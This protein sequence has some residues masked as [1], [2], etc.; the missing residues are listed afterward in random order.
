MEWAD[1]FRAL[2]V[3]TN[4]DTPHDAQVARGFGAEGIGLCRTEHMFFGEGRIH[5][6]REMILAEDTESRKQGPGQAPARCSGMTSTASLRR[7][8]GIRSRSGCSTRRCTSSCRMT[9]APSTE[10]AEDLGVS[11]DDLKQRIQSL[12]EFNPMLGHRGCRLGDH[13]SRD[14]RDAGAGHL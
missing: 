1:E 5:A 6:V 10:S 8:P 9:R 2:K 12:H 14:L 11:V 7:W 13:L 4:A 3:R